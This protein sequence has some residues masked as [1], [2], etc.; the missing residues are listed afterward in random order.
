[1]KLY[2]Y[3]FLS[4]LLFWGTVSASGQRNKTRISTKNANSAVDVETLLKEY[5]FEEASK[6]LQNQISQAT[7]KK[8]PTEELEA[9]AEKAR[10]GANMITATAKIIFVD[11]V[12]V[13]KT[14]ILSAI[15]LD[16]SCGTLNYWKDI[17]EPNK[18]IWEDVT[19]TTTHTNDFKDRILYCYPNEEG[20][21]KLYIR[22]MI[23]SKWSDPDSL[24][25]GEK[26]TDE[27]NPYQLSDGMT[28][29]YGSTAPD[30]L[31]GYDIYVTRYN[32]NTKKYLKAENMGMPYNSTANDYLLA[33]DETNNL[34]WLV[35][36]RNQPEGK[37]CIYIFIPNDTREVYDLDPTEEK[38]RN[39][40]TIHDIAATQEN[41]KSVVMAARQKIKDLASKTKNNT[42]EE[43]SLFC[44][45]IC[46]GVVYKSFQDFKSTKARQMAENW[47]NLY[48]QRNKLLKELKEKRKEYSP[49]IKGNLK[50]QEQALEQL[51]DTINDLEWNIRYEEQSKLGIY[52]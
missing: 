16:K 1:M 23:D 41:N 10:I 27:I 11:S 8:L 22:Y 45:P 46:K 6:A 49:A 37:V 3:I 50:K 32:T 29:Y 28:L 51:D 30:G 21:T 47:K 19:V 38:L 35:S 25:I 7:K 39:L 5:R 33:I 40:A 4:L 48:E 42:A 12:V 24:N 15:K 20:H 34:G 17:F 31:G 44:L 9:M 18:N 2:K 26:E 14:D 36:D 52:K 13:N 43:N